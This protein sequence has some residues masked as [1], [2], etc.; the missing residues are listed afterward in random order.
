M[1]RTMTIGFI[2]ATLLLMSCNT[3]TSSNTQISDSLNAPQKTDTF[4]FDSTKKYI[5]LTFDDGPQPGT[6]EVFHTL[7]SLDVK[8]TFFMVG[9]HQTYSQQM[10]KIV[11][12]VHQAA[13]FFLL[14]N[15]T[16]THASGK[17][18]AFYTN[19]KNAFADILRA[20]DSLRIQQK[21]M[22]LAGNSAWVLDNHFSAHKLVAPVCR[23]L[24]SAGYNVIGWDVEWNM[25]RDPAGPGS[26]PVQGAERMVQ[27]ME[28]A[29]NNNK[30]HIKNCVVLLTHDRMFHRPA[31]RD[32]LYK[33]VKLLKER[34]PNYVF[35]TLDRLP[36]IK[37]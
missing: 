12:S 5:Y 13:P 23:L 6:M 20:Q 37:K 24:D 35:E 31:N 7:K 10:R 2:A 9:L 17:Y 28:Y 14:S 3:N 8:G 11:D 36:G 18:K 27:E 21:I 30:T 1:N 32:S 29:I 26:I 34:N 22:R 25:K 16:Y 19:Y 33:F 15:H 4:A